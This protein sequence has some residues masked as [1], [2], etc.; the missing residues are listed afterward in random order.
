MNPLHWIAS[1][2]YVGKIPYLGTTIATI[3]GI[4]LAIIIRHYYS[5]PIFILIT[6][7]TFLV[8]LATAYQYLKT[9]GVPSEVVID[10]IVGIWI[11]LILAHQFGYAAEAKTYIAAF[12]AFR[13]FDGAK[14]W[15]L[16]IIEDTIGGAFGSMLDDAIAGVYAF[17]GMA[18]ML[19]FYNSLFV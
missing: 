18:A 17:M 7:A 6:V 14:I 12:I 11:A 16:D 3:I 1:F 9:G 4:I 10:E 15:P 19:F 5:E 8:G 2:F 13:I